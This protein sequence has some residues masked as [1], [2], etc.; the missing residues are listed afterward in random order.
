MLL[1]EVSVYAHGQSATVFVSA[2]AVYVNGRR[3]SSAGG[4]NGGFFGDAGIKRQHD[5]HD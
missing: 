4:T 1:V 3:R 2:L 5:T